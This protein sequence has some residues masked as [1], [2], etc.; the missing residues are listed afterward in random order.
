VSFLR[1]PAAFGGRGVPFSCSR[2]DAERLRAPRPA[3]SRAC[4]ASR[5]GLPPAALSVAA[6]RTRSCTPP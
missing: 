4:G 5:S 3:G 2:R 1:G 6:A